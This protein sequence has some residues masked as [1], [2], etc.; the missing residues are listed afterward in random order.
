MNWRVEHAWSPG[1]NRCMSKSNQFIQQMTFKQIQKTLQRHQ[2][3]CLSSCL[4]LKLF[5]FQ[6]YFFCSCAQKIGSTTQSCQ[7]WACHDLLVAATKFAHDKCVF[8]SINWQQTI[9]SMFHMEHAK[10]INNGKPETKPMPKPRCKNRFEV[11]WRVVLDCKS[12]KFTVAIWHQ[13]QKA[14]R[15]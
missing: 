14:M 6:C 8:W 13:L 7:H 4:C 2:P 3:K 11:V 12:H 15:P 10:S 5:H 9:A 1:L